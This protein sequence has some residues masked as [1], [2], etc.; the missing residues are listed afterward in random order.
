MAT[1]T[2]N[3]ASTA[4]ANSITVAQPFWPYTTDIILPLKIKRKDDG[5]YSVYDATSTYDKRIFRGNFKFTATE[6][7][8]LETLIA[9]TTEQ[10]GTTLR[11][12]LT[13]GQGFFPFGTDMMDTGHFN[14]E[15]LSINSKGIGDVPWL[16]FDTEMVWR[17]VSDPGTGL[18]TDASDYGTM[19]IDNQEDAKVEDIRFPENWFQPINQLKTQV[20]SPQASDEVDILDRGESSDRFDTRFRLI[21]KQAKCANLLNVL[22]SESGSR[23]RGSDFLVTTAANSYMFGRQK[24]SNSTYT[25]KLINNT[26]KV[27]HTRH[28]EFHVDLAMNWVSG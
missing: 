18:P 24:G 12:T 19:T 17:M 8:N 25:C 9:D 4:G 7:T 13:S 14:F 27:E 20:S 21:L 16:Y 3:I 6:Q 23:T 26:I 22:V 11:V 5:A 1:P 15:L 2:I 28:D 10:R